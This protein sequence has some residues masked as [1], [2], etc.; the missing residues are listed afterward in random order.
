MFIVY[1]LY[2]MSKAETAL[3]ALYVVKVHVN[4]NYDYDALVVATLCSTYLYILLVSIAAGVCIAR[5]GTADTA[6]DGDGR[7]NW[8]RTKDGNAYLAYLTGT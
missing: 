6:G 5:E 8:V 3:R 1:C 4:Y 2:C 7:A